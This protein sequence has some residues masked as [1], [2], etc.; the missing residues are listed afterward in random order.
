MKTTF[1]VGVFETV[2][3]LTIALSMLSFAGVMAFAVAR[4]DGLI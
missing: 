1:R 4:R 3:L 2:S